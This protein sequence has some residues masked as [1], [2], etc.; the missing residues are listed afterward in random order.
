M[1]FLSG[2]EEFE[3][4]GFYYLH[5]FERDVDTW[6]YAVENCASIFSSSDEEVVPRVNYHRSAVEIHSYDYL[7]FTSSCI[8]FDRVRG[9]RILKDQAHELRLLAKHICSKSRKFAVVSK[10]DDYLFR[11][12]KR[13][14]S[15]HNTGVCTRARVRDDS[16]F[17]FNHNSI[18]SNL[19]SSAL[20]FDNEEVAEMRESI[21]DE[22]WFLHR[23]AK[24]EQNIKK[25][26]A[27][28][29]KASRKRA[30]RNKQQLSQSLEGRPFKFEAVDNKDMEGTYAAGNSCAA[31]LK[32]RFD[33]DDHLPCPSVKTASSSV[34]V[35][36]CSLYD[37]LFR[38]NIGV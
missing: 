6:E 12:R 36:K 1:E 23:A 14:L 2:E 37:K 21:S 31:L 10:D 34:E 30:Q 25:E 19:T 35:S 29:R 9:L 18:K 13:N 8:P 7:E 20:G 5:E 11:F 15:L 26:K 22:F 33:L 24:K 4:E 17:I 28:V 16:M 27:A 32:N 38:S 3:E